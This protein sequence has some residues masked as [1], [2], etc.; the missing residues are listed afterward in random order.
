M[1]LRSLSG[2]AEYETASVSNIHVRIL[3]KGLCHLIMISQGAAGCYEKMNGMLLH[4]GARLPKEMRGI[5]L[6]ETEK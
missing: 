6:G 1:C 3:I 5:F 2:K 4:G